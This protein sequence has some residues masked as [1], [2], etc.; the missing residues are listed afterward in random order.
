[1]N[2]REEIL[3][4]IESISPLPVS[5]MRL[6]EL[7]L[8]PETRSDDICRCMKDE[9]F[10]D[11]LL[12]FVNSP[13]FQKGTFFSSLHEME[14][15]LGNKRLRELAI[16]AAVK[17]IVQIPINEYDISTAEM[18]RHCLAVA[19]GAEELAKALQLE[20]PDFLFLA[21]FLHDIGKIMLDQYELTDAKEILKEAF[22]SQISVVAA[23]KKLHGIDHGEVGAILLRKWK[24]PA[25]VIQSTRWHHHP[26]ACRDDV[27]M[28]D[29][30]NVSDSFVLMIG[31]GVGSEGLYYPV[32]NEIEE[33][34]LLTTKIVERVISQIQIGLEQLEPFFNAESTG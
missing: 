12:R 14:K 2:R 20:T 34:L 6:I 27:L 26:I 30:I 29:L 19:I 3:A 25:D 23:E 11:E 16:V 8:N 32:Y 18:I 22:T 17:P 13:Y 5:T 28:L 15:E 21:G 24:M 33:R 10:V 7:G 1:M 4:K 9:L 31:I